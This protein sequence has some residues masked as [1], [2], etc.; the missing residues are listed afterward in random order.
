[1]TKEFMAYIY[2]LEAM[3]GVGFKLYSAFNVGA[4]CSWINY[5]PRTLEEIERGY[6]RWMD[7]C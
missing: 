5:V 7:S 1:M 3:N 6:K 2:C 4:M